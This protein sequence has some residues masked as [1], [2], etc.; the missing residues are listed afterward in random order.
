MPSAEFFVRVVQRYVPTYVCRL[1]VRFYLKVTDGIRSHT[2]TH[3]LT[4][5]SSGEI[6]RLNIACVL[7]CCRC[8]R[9]RSVRFDRPVVVVFASRVVGVARAHVVVD[10]GAHS[11]F[12]HRSISIG[13]SNASQ[14][15][16]PH[17]RVPATTGEREHASQRLRRGDDR[18]PLVSGAV[19]CR[20][21]SGGTPPA[22]RPKDPHTAQ[23]ALLGRSA[24]DDD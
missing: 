14:R 6:D 9:A 7:F 10:F 17:A 19:S 23:R 12:F 1:L 2:H 15:T 24:R 22:P 21:C 5:N 3:T 8:A 20:L 13:R 16:H 18:T 4:S 11:S